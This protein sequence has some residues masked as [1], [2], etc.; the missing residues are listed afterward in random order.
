MRIGSLFSGLSDFADAF[1]KGFLAVGL[2]TV[3]TGL[4]VWLID[5]L[6]R[7]RDR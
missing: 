5:E 7:W 3:I 1:E 6:A 4:I 2:I